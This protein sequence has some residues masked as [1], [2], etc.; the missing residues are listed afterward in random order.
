M[1]KHIDILSYLVNYSFPPCIRGVGSLTN[2]KPFIDDL[3]ITKIPSL[4]NKYHISL[5][6]CIYQMSHFSWFQG[7]YIGIEGSNHQAGL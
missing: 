2:C 6:L 7:H 4:H 3:P 1:L 5:R